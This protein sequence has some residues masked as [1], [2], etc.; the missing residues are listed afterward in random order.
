MKTTKTSSATA[1]KRQAAPP[2]PTL[3]TM[4]DGEDQQPERAA[5]APRYQTFTVRFLVEPD[6]VCRRTEVAHVQDGVSEA[7]AGHDTERLTRWIGE[8]VAPAA[9]EAE[10]PPP[11]LGPAPAPSQ[12]VRPVLRDLNVI[13]S[14]EGGSGHHLLAAGQPLTSY[15]VL[16]LP[17][18][19]AGGEPVP[20]TVTAFGRDLCGGHMALGEARGQ[21]LPGRAHVVE[22]PGIAGPPGVYRIG[23]ALSLDL[24]GSGAASL[25]GGLVHIY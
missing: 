19:E 9:P 23:V 7:W 22:V 20:Y 2:A 16:E 3:V 13:G 12:P 18:P 25:S 21:A 6:G 1:R 10:A 8:R 4:A 11:D 17:G 14:G 24:P 15:V 5:D